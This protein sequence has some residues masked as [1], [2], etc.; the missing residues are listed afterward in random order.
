MKLNNGD[1][2]RPERYQWCEQNQ[3]TVRILT[4]FRQD[5]T[6]NESEELTVR[7]WW[8]SSRENGKELCVTH[9]YKV[10][11]FFTYSVVSDV[12]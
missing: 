5:M 7:W 6:S 2:K 9:F 11:I 1:E 8:W 3:W 10:A 12:K 4:V